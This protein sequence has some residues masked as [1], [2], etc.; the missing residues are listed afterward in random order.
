MVLLYFLD[1]IV[2]HTEAAERAGAPPAP[3]RLTTDVPGGGHRRG[4]G[5]WRDELYHDRHAGRNAYRAWLLA[6]RHGLGDPEPHH[7][8]VPAI[9]VHRLPAGKL[10]LRRVMLVGLA[11]PAGL[12]RAGDDQP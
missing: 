2:P 8:H 6:G 4:G 3:G 5:V 9:A 7:R 1:E 11:V 10:G 12:R